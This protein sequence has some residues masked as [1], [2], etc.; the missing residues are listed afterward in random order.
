MVELMEESD[1]LGSVPTHVGV[2]G[3]DQCPPPTATLLL[4]L[5]VRRNLRCAPHG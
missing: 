1:E 4:P 2:V 5:T 3:T